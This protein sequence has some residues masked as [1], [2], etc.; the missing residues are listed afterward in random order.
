MRDAAM[1]SA[2]AAPRDRAVPHRLVIHAGRVLVVETDH[3]EET[4]KDEKRKRDEHSGHE[5]HP[6]VDVASLRFKYLEHS[7]TGSTPANVVVTDDI[8]THV[9]SGAPAF[10]LEG[11]YQSLDCGELTLMPG[12]IDAH[13][14]VTASSANLRMPSTMPPS[15]LYARAVPILSG[16]LDRGF[17]TVR[18]CGGADHGLAQAIDEGTLRGP[19]VVHCGKALSQTGGHGDFRGAG[20]NALNSGACKCCDFTIARVCDG[21]DACRAAVREEVRKGARHVKVMASG[22]VASPT[23]RLENLQF[24]QA[25][26]VAICD[27]ARNAGVY[28]AAHAYTDEAISRAVRCGVTSVEHGNFCGDDTLRLLRDNHGFLVPTLITYHALREEGEACGMSSVSIKKIGHL[29]ARGQAT[30]RR[31]RDLHV[32]VCYGS[33]LLGNMHRHQSRSIALHLDAGLDP[34]HVLGS[35]TAVP[36]ARVP[37]PRGK[38]RRGRLEAVAPLDGAPR[39]FVAAGALAD[40][41]LVDGDPL[42][43][44]AVLM[45]EKNIKVVV[46]GGRVVKDIRNSPS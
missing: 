17:T 11:T 31:A 12:L 45:D 7:L 23:D 6:G 42:A 3:C 14:H 22:G 29:V 18:D 33:D 13:V 36:G 41:I 37:E 2:A 32:P 34:H 39:G 28:V 19:R 20:E 9:E 27:D 10:E 4:A 26:L 44:P 5:H 43:D 35:L 30:L 46:K 15:L 24:S 40:L 38:L 16:M 8:I 25:E 21:V 1:A